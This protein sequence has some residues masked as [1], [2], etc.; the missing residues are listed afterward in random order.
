MHMGSLGS[1]VEHML[2]RGGYAPEF[3]GSDIRPVCRTWAP[4][5]EQPSLRAQA[6]SHEYQVSETS[7][8]SVAVRTP[9]NEV[10]SIPSEKIGLREFL[11]HGF[12]LTP[13]PRPIRKF[14]GK[15][16]VDPKPFARERH[17]SYD[18][19][20]FHFEL[21]SSVHYT[22][23]VAQRSYGKGAKSPKGSQSG[24]ERERYSTHK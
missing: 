18:N 22:R 21:R 16:Q 6:N 1:S 15:G 7:R 24:T 8:D 10:G 4:R 3:S 2:A 17:H 5:V 12:S 20:R 9:C 19:V 23:G 11:T 13:D 14:K